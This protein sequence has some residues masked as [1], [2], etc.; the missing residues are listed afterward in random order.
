MAQ[1][2]RRQQKTHQPWLRDNIIDPHASRR[3]PGFSQ[4]NIRGHRGHLQ[5]QGVELQKSPELE[6]LKH[7][8]ISSHKLFGIYG[9]GCVYL[10]VDPPGLRKMQAQSLSRRLFRKRRWYQVDR[11]L[12]AGQPCFYWFSARVVYKL[13]KDE[14]LTSL[15]V[16]VDLGFPRGSAKFHHMY[17]VTLN[18]YLPF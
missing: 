18:L 12:F 8:M 4:G 14:F 10:S 11:W 1:F 7:F 13:P 5:S 6:N 16:M 17:C 15:T 3:S 9:P 2:D